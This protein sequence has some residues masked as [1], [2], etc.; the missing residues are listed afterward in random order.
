[1]PWPY[2]LCLGATPCPGIRVWSALMR[3]TGNG[4]GKRMVLQR[5]FKI[6]VPALNRMNIGQ[7]NTTNFHCKKL[8]KPGIWKPFRFS[9]LFCASFFYLLK[10]FFLCLSDSHDLH[11]GQNLPAPRL[12]DCYKSQPPE[13]GDYPIQN[14]KGRILSQ[15]GSG[16]H[17]HSNDLTQAWGCCC[18]IVQ[19]DARSPLLCV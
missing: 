4:A 6:L 13:G 2:W 11:N 17:L 5:K 16:A 7:A 8:P 1:M 19:S 15:L 3:M 12:P 14:S 10:L 9:F 18:S